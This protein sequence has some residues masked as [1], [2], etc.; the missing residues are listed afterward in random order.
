MRND[1][2]D[3][4]G[5]DALL[6]ELVSG[7][8]DAALLAR[9]ADE[10]GT[11]SPEQRT[12]V[13]ARLSES[14]AYADQLRLLENFDLSALEQTAEAEEER[15]RIRLRELPASRHLARRLG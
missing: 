9:F 2:G 10:P 4:A 11:L 7:E 5:L 13:E 15:P 14:P 8:A 3:E 12:R 1:Q 6:A